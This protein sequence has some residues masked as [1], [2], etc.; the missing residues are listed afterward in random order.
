MAMRIQHRDL[1]R[2]LVEP[3]LSGGDVVTGGEA[4]AHPDDQTIPSPDDRAEWQQAGRRLVFHRWCAVRG[5]IDQIDGFEQGA[6]LQ[7]QG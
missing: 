4:R 6:D 7:A 3:G 5:P 1:D 2:V